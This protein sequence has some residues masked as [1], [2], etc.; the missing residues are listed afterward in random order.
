M[1]KEPG[2][3]RFRDNIGVVSK[4][5]AEIAKLQSEMEGLRV[6]GKKEGRQKN[7]DQRIRDLQSDVWK[8]YM[9][10]LKGG[11]AIGAVVLAVALL[12][13]AAVNKGESVGGGEFGGDSGAAD[14]PIPP[15]PGL[16][17]CTGL[18]GCPDDMPQPKPKKKFEFTDYQPT[19]D[20]VIVKNV[21]RSP[22]AKSVIYIPDYHAMVKKELENTELVV[23]TQS[24][25]VAMMKQLVAEY[26]Q[27]PVVMEDVPFGFSMANVAANADLSTDPT[28]KDVSRLLQMSDAKSREAEAY[29]LLMD[30]RLPV[31]QYLLIAMP[32]SIVPVFSST[33][34]Q[35]NADIQRLEMRDQAV[36]AKITM[37]LAEFSCKKLP[38][39]PDVDAFVKDMVA[40]F[41]KGDR[42][43]DV[44][45]C[46]C[47]YRGFVNRNVHPLTVTRTVD[48]PRR[49]AAAAMRSK[50]DLVV[51]ISGVGHA[52]NM[53][54]ELDAGGVNY[55]V[56]APKSIEDLVRQR[57]VR[58]LDNGEVMEGA[59]ECGEEG[60]LV[61][62]F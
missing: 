10:M 41:L 38:G 24:H 62:E 16:I 18:I 6:S 34:D 28:V 12:V 46:F 51:V 11:G 4:S 1:S 61:V 29:K 33:V 40:R 60:R 19:G 39:N 25:T 21:F 47:A 5:H 13:V 35:I 37:S 3:F 14:G 42:S 32:D 52:T 55:M 49:E 8:A 57:L 48:A 17:D 30:G 44:V 22:D 15:D 56:M 20:G 45:A 53:V 54:K 26:G 27:I 31:G 9:R 59:S 2:I 36:R 43:P 7:L 50:G 58:R 23:A